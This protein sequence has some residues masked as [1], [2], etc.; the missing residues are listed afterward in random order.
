MAYRWVH[1]L[2]LFAIRLEAGLRRESPRSHPSPTDERVFVGQ[3]EGG[4]SL[5]FTFGIFMVRGM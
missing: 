5:C 4:Y 3:D 2:R 1:P